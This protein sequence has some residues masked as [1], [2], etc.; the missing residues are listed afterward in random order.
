M[1]TPACTHSFPDPYPQPVDQI[2][3]CR[4]CG[5]S[6]R[7]AKA[8][9]TPAEE[10][11]AAADTLAPATDTSPSLAVEYPDLDACYAH[12]LR[13]TAETCDAVTRHGL[14]LDETAHWLAPALAAA[15]QIN[16]ADPQP[17][18][19][20]CICRQSVHA[21]EHKGRTIDSCPWCTPAPDIRPKPARTD[22]MPTGDLP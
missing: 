6:Y 1:T 20:P 14:D 13:T 3:N 12:M 4:N 15:R 11:R 2:G 10:L 9:A 16:G 21:E 18:L 22:T 17:P 7:D 5:T 19:S 8:A